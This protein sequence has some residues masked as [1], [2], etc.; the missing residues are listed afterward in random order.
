MHALRLLLTFALWIVFG[1]GTAWLWWTI[2]SASP[3]PTD[4]FALLQ[5]ASIP[6]RFGA[7]LGTSIWLWLAWGAADSVA[8]HALG[9]DKLG[10]D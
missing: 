2:M 8:L 5:E 1:L 4:W 7:G 9:L 3:S 6:K 10:G